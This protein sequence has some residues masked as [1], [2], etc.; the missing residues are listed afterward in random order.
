VAALI[1]QNGDIYEDQLGPKYETLRAYWANPTSEGRQKLVDAVSEKGFRDEFVG[2]IDQRRIE[3][4]PP[5]LWKLRAGALYSH[6]RAASDGCYGP[7]HVPEGADC[8]EPALAGC[9]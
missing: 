3:R 1:I 8:E 2:K 5:D 6:V 9:G 7:D 4:I